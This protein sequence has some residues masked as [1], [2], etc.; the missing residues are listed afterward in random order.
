MA[1][2]RRYKELVFTN[3]ALE[4]LNQRKVAM[5]ETWATWRRPD[6]KYYAA[7]KQ[8]WVFSRNWRHRQIEVVAKQND[9]KEWVVLSV[10]SNYV[11]FRAKQSWLMK[12]LRW[13]WRRII[14]F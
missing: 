2:Q 11:K 8:A 10:W 13:L 3:H 12:L 6:K 1:N 5:S 7:T 4:R 14:R 9:R